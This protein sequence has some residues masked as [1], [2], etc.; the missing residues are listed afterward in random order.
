MKTR[1][2]NINKR[3]KVYASVSTVAGGKFF[4]FEKKGVFEKNVCN[5]E[6][7]EQFCFLLSKPELKELIK[8]LEESI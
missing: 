8:F 7:T 2:T 5:L 4:E 3:I 6:K 1:E